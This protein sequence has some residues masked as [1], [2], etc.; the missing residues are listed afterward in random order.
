MARHEALEATNHGIDWLQRP[1]DR[2]VSVSR[3]LDV[4]PMN[5]RIQ[6][7]LLIKTLSTSTGVA[8]ILPQR[9]PP[10]WRLLGTESQ[11]ILR[12]ALLTR[13][14]QQKFASTKAPEADSPRV[15]IAP[16]CGPPR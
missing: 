8:N 7:A 16:A 1:R 11:Q 15:N 3:P 6:A 4:N 10:P 5:F 9:P 13:V 12:E 2:H 14:D